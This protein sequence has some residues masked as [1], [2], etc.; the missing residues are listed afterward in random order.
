MIDELPRL[1]YIVD[2]SV[3]ATAH[4]SSLLYR[5]FE[6]YPP[7]KLI[8]LEPELRS[9]ESHSSLSRLRGFRYLFIPFPFARLFKSQ[10]ARIARSAYFLLSW[11]FLRRISSI[12][13]S[14]PI[15]G[16]VSVSNGILWYPAFLY[17]RSRN[18]SFFLIIHDDGLLASRS[19]INKSIYYRRFRDAYLY[20]TQ[21]F[22]ICDTM[23]K[24]YSKTFK[25]KSLTLWPSRSASAFDAPQRM[26]CILNSEREL[27]IAY[28]GSI[29]S[30][31]YAKM[32]GILAGLKCDYNIKVL[33]YG[34]H[35]VHSLSFVGLDCANI[36][37]M[38]NFSSDD[39]VLSLRDNADILYLPIPFDRSSR[40]IAR[41]S[42]PSK[43]VDYTRVG[44]PIL[45]Q[46]PYYS[47]LT[48]WLY[49]A[50]HA[51][52]LVDTLSPFDLKRAINCI[53]NNDYAMYSKG[54]LE[55]G[56]QSFDYYSIAS[57]FFQALAHDSDFNCHSAI[58]SQ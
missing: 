55:A 51:A 9:F 12:L 31:Q 1:A 43:L 7:N 26:E 53:I 44:I 2:V 11:I 38:G 5:L 15:D 6:K 24:F 13:D 21:V 39:L 35:S 28:A 27:N 8:I 34:S 48:S 40:H 41:Y 47:S 36:Y 45:A 50:P 56:R 46:A 52:Y 57:T 17:A 23:N 49:S 32:I 33:I 18:I 16:I 30:E 19:L 22:C 10:F 58:I 25:K 54:G 14:L 37:C 29:N 20:A 4:G 3:S 42:F